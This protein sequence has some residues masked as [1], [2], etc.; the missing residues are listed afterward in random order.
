M[1]RSAFNQIRFEI[2][3]QKNQNAA[4]KMGHMKTNS[5]C[6]INCHEPKIIFKTAQEP[7]V[8][9]ESQLLMTFV[10]ETKRVRIVFF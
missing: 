10:D 9:N 4:E 5:N 3:L 8:V 1:L 2:I 6:E 7:K